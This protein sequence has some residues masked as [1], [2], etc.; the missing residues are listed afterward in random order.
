[1]RCGWRNPTEAMSTSLGSHR[2]S[3]LSTCRHC[4]EGASSL[5]KQGSSRSEQG[6]CTRAAGPSPNK[7]SVMIAY[8]LARWIIR[9][10]DD[11]T[12]DNPQ[13]D[14]VTAMKRKIKDLDYV[15]ELG[16]QSRTTSAHSPVLSKK[17]GEC[18]LSDVDN[19]AS[20]R[21]SADKQL[22]EPTNQNTRFRRF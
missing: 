9:Y 11:H 12:C 21:S 2:C 8:L 17:L 3:L 13:P 16:Q 4:K 7:F 1:M 19:S 14:S 5:Q 10:K 15:K 20:K 6:H 18:Q 22:L